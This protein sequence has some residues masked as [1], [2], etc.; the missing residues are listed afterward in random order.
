MLQAVPTQSTPI[1]FN[2]HT[3]ANLSFTLLDALNQAE[4]LA[5]KHPD[6]QAVIYQRL[7]A[8]G[9]LVTHVRLASE[10]IPEGAALVTSIDRQG[11]A[12]LGRVT[13]LTLAIA[14]TLAHLPDEVQLAPY[15]VMTRNT[16]PGQ[17]AWPTLPAS[18]ALVDLD[19]PD[20]QQAFSYELM[21][22]AQRNIAT[23][24]P[25]LAQVGP[26]VQ[27]HPG[28]DGLGRVLPLAEQQTKV[29]ISGLIAMAT[30][31]LA[32]G[33]IAPRPDSLPASDAP[34]RARARSGG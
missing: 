22:R 3:H 19:D 31:L 25:M 30:D 17:D 6:D 4:S 9:A 29:D 21:T 32:Q 10:P 18:H 34:V 27:M 5:K 26:G 12:T 16:L 8:D 2:I 20:Q 33:W 28:D 24:A 7:G 23:Y 1:M 14:Q 13:D 15:A 11:L